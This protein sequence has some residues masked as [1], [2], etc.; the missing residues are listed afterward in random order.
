MSIGRL[1]KRRFLEDALNA[2]DDRLRLSD[3]KPAIQNGVARVRLGSK[4]IEMRRPASMESIEDISKTLWS[5][6]HDLSR[7]R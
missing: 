2:S 1:R 5:G 3:V 6:L 4:T 7:H